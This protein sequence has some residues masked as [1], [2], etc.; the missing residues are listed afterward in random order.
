MAASRGFGIAGSALFGFTLLAF[1]AMTMGPLYTVLKSRAIVQQ[2]KVKVPGQQTKLIPQGFEAGGAELIE[3]IFGGAGKA[4]LY[5]PREVGSFF[6]LQGGFQRSVFAHETKHGRS[7]Q[8][9]NSQEL[10]DFADS[11]K[12]PLPSPQHPYG[13]QLSPPANVISIMT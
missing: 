2:N 6:S 12:V 5:A 9:Y 7:S 10:N 8:T 4:F 13:N 3:G 1:T 11:L